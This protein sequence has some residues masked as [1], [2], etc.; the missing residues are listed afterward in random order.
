MVDLRSA[1]ARDVEAIVDL[2]QTSAGPTRS[3]GGVAEVRGLLQRD[4][5]AL[6]VADDDGA[7]VGTVVVGW[8][9]WRCH[10][11]RLA[12]REERRRGGI[13]AALVAEARQRAARAGAT[14]LDAMVH[15]ENTG[16]VAF[17]ERAGF[18]LGDD[19]GRWSSVLDAP[20][21]DAPS[22]G[23][24]QVGVLTGA[25]VRLEPLVHAHVDGLV[26]AASE[27]RAT[28]GFTTV[29]SD[30]ASAVAYV[31]ELVAAR[32]AGDAVPFAQVSVATGR[33]VGATRIFRLRRAADTG[34]LFAVE[35]GGTWL[36]ADAQ[37]TG[38]NGEAKLLL[39]QQAFDGWGVRRVELLTDARNER[40]RAAIAGIG[41]TFEGVARNAHESRAPGEARLLRDS[42]IFS[43]TDAEWPDV[44]R[45]LERRLADGGTR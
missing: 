19:D 43:I 41:A 39:L 5:D 22:A 29:P 24:L 7:I 18:E 10:L 21:P 2:W 12:V 26:E 20:V 8:D 28:Y 32:D 44:R 11:Y 25:R 6:V 1:T 40:S 23:D 13:A 3:P 38:V 15:R 9:G 45:G 36:A 14:R 17:W 4:A 27:D 34:A 33:V 31:D 16:A 42:A 35:I 30:R 37:R